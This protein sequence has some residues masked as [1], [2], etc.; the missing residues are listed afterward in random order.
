MNKSC[1]VWENNF[2]T[3][4]SNQKINLHK[5]TVILQPGVHLAQLYYI[6]SKIEGIRYMVL[7]ILKSQ[8]CIFWSFTT[9]KLRGYGYNDVTRN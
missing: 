4:A 9:L 6:C 7:G 3:G 1:G 5:R 8:G 2:H